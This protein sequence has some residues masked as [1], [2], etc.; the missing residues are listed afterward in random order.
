MS[1]DAI[2]CVGC[3]YNLRSLPVDGPCPECGR[4]ISASLGGR[5]LAAADPRW[6][7]RLSIGQSLITWGLHVA[8]VVLFL[9]ARLATVMRQYRRAFRAAHDETR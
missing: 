1:D 9:L 2:Y 8:L 4:A 6:L 5:R 7:A 3:G